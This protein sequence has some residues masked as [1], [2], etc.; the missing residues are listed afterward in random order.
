M[1]DKIK[2][3][4]NKMIY[5]ITAHTI[6]TLIFCAIAYRWG[7]NDGQK[8]RCAEDYNRGYLEGMKDW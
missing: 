2:Y 8:I 7:K 1:C 4:N 3:R 5:I 6:I